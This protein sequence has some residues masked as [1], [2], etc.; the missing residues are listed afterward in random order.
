M[1][2]RAF[3]TGKF[4]EKVLALS[5]Y[6]STLITDLYNNTANKQ[7]IIRGAAFLIKNYFEEYMDAR[8]RQS[9]SSYHHVYE[10]DRTGDKSARLFKGTVTNSND[11]AVITY[12]FTQAKNSNREGHEFPNKAETMEKNDPIMIYPKN[13]KYLQ[14]RLDSGKFV[15][16]EGVY[17][18]NP[19]GPE[20][21]NS[22]EKTFDN[23][24]KT[25][26]YV[27]LQKFGFFKRIEQSIISKR[28]LVIPRI[29]SGIV[30][31]ALR[32]AR[33]DAAQIS[34]GVGSLYV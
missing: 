9:P 12:K 30:S 24:M 29:N 31:D 6:D 28:K 20:V 33:R 5:T 7:K 3:N 4:S 32:T 15:K 18:R 16:S 27:A 14:F 13:A 34:G 17:V 10:F 25:Q 21:T 2:K 19:G 22:F 23:F 8:A 26:G 1:A 11:G